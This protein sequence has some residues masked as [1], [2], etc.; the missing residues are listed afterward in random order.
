MTLFSTKIFLLELVNGKNYI[1]PTGVLIEKSNRALPGPQKFIVPKVKKLQCENQEVAEFGY[2]VD[3]VELKPSEI[4]QGKEIKYVARQ[5]WDDGIDLAELYAEVGE[6]DELE[7]YENNRKCGIAK[8][9][10]IVCLQDKE[11]QKEGGIDIPAPAPREVRT[12]CETVVIITCNPKSKIRRICKAYIEAAKTAKY[13]KVITVKSDG[14][15]YSVLK[16]NRA[17][18]EFISDPDEFVSKRGREWYFCK[19]KRGSTKA[20]LDMTEI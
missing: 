4:A 18:K 20:C 3:K 9:L 16:T 6:C 1:A 7:T 15:G 12:H 19:C 5:D 17:L 8:S 2:W 14:T 10:L 11:V 13:Q